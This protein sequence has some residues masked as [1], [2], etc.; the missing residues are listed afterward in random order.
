MKTALPF[1]RFSPVMFSGLLDDPLLLIRK[2]PK[3][4]N[5]LV[6]C[7][8]IAHVAKRVLKSITRI[9]I[10]HSHMDHFIGIDC[11][12]RN[13][14]V[15]N[16]LIKI[17]GPPGTA[18]K[19]GFR[20]KGFEW[21]LIEDYFCSLEVIEYHGAETEHY[22][23]E[24]A[25]GFELSFQG[26]KASQNGLLEEDESFTTHTIALDH[27]IPVLAYRFTEKPIFQISEQKIDTNGY[28]KGDWISD[29]KHWHSNPEQ[30]KQILVPEKHD[31]AN[32]VTVKI[33]P[34]TLFRKIAKEVEMPGIGYVSDI[35][36]TP[37]NIRG[38][39]RLL[40]G[41]TLLV[42]ECTYMKSEK[43]KARES[44]HLCTDDLNRIVDLIRPKYL[45]P[46][47]M[48]KSYLGQSDKLFNELSLPDDC[49][50]LKL[51]ERVASM[52]LRTKDTPFF[53]E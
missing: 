41:V 15:T 40:N 17:F 10:T 14:L 12:V 6:D 26:R 34:E 38:L 27:K 36:Y 39:S 20:L 51:P 16:K 5:I 44:Y 2:K 19:L 48:S 28:I 47:H 13:V 24:G 33:A 31:N 35:G 43:N 37:E 42:C 21:N 8:Q 23:L 3:T 32:P 1:H 22:L 18:E 9:F 45:I 30:V 7:G 29:L 25:R 11:F 46:I 53:E 4:G 49:M 50:M 52:P